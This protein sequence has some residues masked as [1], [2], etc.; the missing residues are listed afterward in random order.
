[1]DHAV[2]PARAGSR[3]IAASVAAFGSAQILA[4]LLAFLAIH[5]YLAMHLPTATLEG[6]FL[7]VFGGAIQPY[8]DQFNL[9]VSDATAY[10]LP[11][12]AISFLTSL[13][14]YAAMRHLTASPLAPALAVVWLNTS[15]I[16]GIGSLFATT[17][18]LGAFGLS[19]AFWGFSA[20]RHR[21][22]RFAWAIAG[23][24][25]AIA[26][27]SHPAAGWAI[28]AAPLAMLFDPACRNWL[29]RP[30]F[31]ACMGL[32]GCVQWVGFDGLSTMIYPPDPLIV[33]TIVLTCLGPGLLFLFVVGSVGSLA[34]QSPRSNALPL[35]LVIGLLAASATG[36]ADLNSLAMLAPVIAA[37]AALAASEAK[38]ALRNW[39]AE[40]TTPFA[41]IFM[42]LG[43]YV[44]G[45]PT[46]AFLPRLSHL[47][48]LFG[49][50]EIGA[51][52][53]EQATARRAGYV[54]TDDPDIARN[55]SNFVPIP[56]LAGN[57]DMAW[58]VPDCEAPGIFLSRS[59]DA[60]D[61]LGSFRQISRI[62]EVNRIAGA[63]V[64][65]VMSIYSVARPTNQAGCPIE[66]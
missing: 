29:L 61:L 40:V 16:F 17:E 65:D 15:I 51:Q 32:V 59:D 10:R 47:N 56:V 24:G 34:G 60:N 58:I 57:P 41:F 19:L 55:L 66:P 64:I 49:W 31:F 50:Q 25:A 4:L 8:L 27:L 54:L 21:T 6:E 28:L 2:Q 42:M 46:N 33:A 7:R 36:A 35:A 26:A 39:L 1:M 45:S 63:W 38:G 37:S 30:G 11:F 13:T 5:T 12:L 14:L 44:I 52:V 62:N 53:T 18:A 9:P 43:I 48:T 3:A 22:N 20:A 23:T